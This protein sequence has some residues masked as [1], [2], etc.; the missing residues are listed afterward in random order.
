LFTVKPGAV[1]LKLIIY[2][3]IGFV[4]LTV[5]NLIYRCCTREADP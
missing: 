1:K 5:F 2:K 3:L 4:F